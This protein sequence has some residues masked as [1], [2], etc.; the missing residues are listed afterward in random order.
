[1]EPVELQR[2]VN[3]SLQRAILPPVAI[4][5]GQPKSKYRNDLA[6]FVG[7]PSDTVFSIARM[8]IE[9]D[10]NAAHPK[11]AIAR[12]KAQPERWRTPEARWVINSVTSRITKSPGDVANGLLVEFAVM[13]SDR[14]W[15]DWRTLTGTPNCGQH[16][17]A[18]AIQLVGP[19]VGN[20]TADDLFTFVKDLYYDSSQGRCV[21]HFVSVEG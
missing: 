7:Q 3:D 6:I 14:Q 9:R 21:E 10:T 20:L 11:Y 19:H 1:M 5:Q 13:Q 2:K 18:E 12:A 8:G 15:A 16:W 17:I 4:H